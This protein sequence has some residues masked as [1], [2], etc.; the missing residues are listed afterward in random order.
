MNYEEL[1]KF[2]KENYA[3][4]FD[5]V[6]MLRDGS[7]N[8]VL[9]LQGKDKKYVVRVS[10]RNVEDDI[11][12]ETE[13]LKFLKDKKIPVVPP[14]ESKAGKGYSVGRAGL[15]VV[16]F[17]FVDGRQVELGEHLSLAA[18]EKAAMMLAAIHN[19]S[20]GNSVSRN[21]AKT[22]FSELERAV[23]S[24][25]D[26]ERKMPSGGEFM[27]EVDTYLQWGKNYR[28]EPVLVH[29]DYRAGN[30]LFNDELEIVA[31]LDFDRSLMGPAIKDVAHSLAEWSY[32]DG[33]NDHREAVFAA[34]FEGYNKAADRKIALSDDL[35]RWIAFGCLSDASTYLMDN[36]ERGEVKDPAKSYMYQKF[37]YFSDK[38]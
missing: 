32:P 34:F 3:I 1:S 37:K 8:V 28:Y 14:V 2:I 27:K 20:R 17:P 6:K 24:K 21:R 9:I 35:Y 10:K 18:V 38:E 19:V 25:A 36:L 13:W 26:I 5:A 12:F 4:D 16:V 29:N 11:E 23:S 33:A 22:V 7:D 30:V 15:V 31:V